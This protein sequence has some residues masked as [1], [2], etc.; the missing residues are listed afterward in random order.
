MKRIKI[1]SSIFKNKKIIPFIIFTQIVMMLLVILPSYNQYMKQKKDYEKHINTALN[2]AILYMGNLFY[3]IRHGKEE[4]N[5]FEELEENKNKIYNFYKNNRDIFK[6]IT[7]TSIEYHYE[8]EDKNLNFELYDEISF[9]IIHDE[10]KNKYD[11]SKYDTDKEIP[12]IVQSKFKN[13]YPI[14]SI[15]DFKVKEDYVKFKI[16]GYYDIDRTFDLG[17][18][19]NAP[20]PL[21]NLFRE[22]REIIYPRFISIYRENLSKYTCFNKVAVQ[23]ATLLYLKDDL[24][25]KDFKKIESFIEDNSLGYFLYTKDLFNSQL[26]YND[27]I[28]QKFLDLIIAFFV[29][30]I[31]TFIGIGYINKDLLEKRYDIY[32]LNG[33]S[34][35]DL[36]IITFIYYTI[37]ILGSICIYQLVMWICNLEFIANN[38][39]K[40][41]INL[42][43]IIQDDNILHST[44]FIFLFIVLLIVISIISFW[45]LKKVKRLYEE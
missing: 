5:N 30:I 10:M 41:S 16:I 7:P 34:N 42:T 29:I 9:G 20:F 31:F 33:A 3:N 23:N 39:S 19:T 25:Q 15:V 1:L 12:V 6:N 35:K 40:H 28:F 45:P 13:I 38:L 36:Y 11:F 14:D 24:T 44:E 8:V 17:I 2:N 37:M 18:V 21:T 22:N 26:E 43:R 4:I 27:Q 32:K